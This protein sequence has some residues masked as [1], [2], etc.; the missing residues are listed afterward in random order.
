M[1]NLSHPVVIGSVLVF[2]TGNHL[3]SHPVWVCVY[4]MRKEVPISQTVTQ[5]GATR[6]TQ[7]RKNEH[8]IRNANDCPINKTDKCI[9][10]N[11]QSDWKNTDLSSVLK[12]T[13][14][15]SKCLPFAMLRVFSADT[16][17]M[18]CS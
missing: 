17:L 16:S 12:V 10:G 1:K 15:K 4:K 5:T 9:L 2:I 8:T 13:G 6:H 18:L 11:C 7:A 14:T 3:G